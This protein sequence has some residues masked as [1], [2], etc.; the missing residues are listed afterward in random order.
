MYINQNEFFI[1]GFPGEQE[2][3][4]SKEREEEEEEEEGGDEE[5]GHRGSSPATAK[6]AAP[7]PAARDLV[8]HNPIRPLLANVRTIIQREWRTIAQVFPNHGV[9]MKKFLQRVFAQSI[10]IQLESVLEQGEAQSPLSYLRVLAACHQ[11]VGALV[12]ELHRLDETVMAKTTGE[13]ILTNLLNRSFDD[14]FVAFIEGDRYLRSE[15]KCLTDMFE[16]LLTPFHHYMVRGGVCV[17]CGALLLLLLGCSCVRVDRRPHLVF[18][19]THLAISTDATRQD[20][21]EGRLCP[22]PGELAPQGPDDGKYHGESVLC[23]GRQLWRRAGGG[24][25][26][27]DG[28]GGV[29]RGRGHAH[30]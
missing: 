5:P 13:P 17:G 15:R 1:Q 18:I 30:P 10:Q 24:L 12:G 7:S 27:G 20:P 3:R 11:D 29:S 6:G 26:S 9:V 8:A 16:A 2:A 23:L 28:G 14:L 22:G 25:V 21:Q 19:P 4:P